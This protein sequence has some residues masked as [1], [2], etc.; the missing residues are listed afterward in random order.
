MRRSPTPYSLHAWSSLRGWGSLRVWKLPA[1]V[2]MRPRLW[3]T[4]ARVGLRMI[5]P[6]WWARA[7]YLP[8]PPRAYLRFRLQ[9]ALGSENSTTLEAA[10]LIRW[11]EWCRQWPAAASAYR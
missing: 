4:A 7:P 1:A 5:P 6:R 9:T 11:L 3:C 10:D 2:A 8:V